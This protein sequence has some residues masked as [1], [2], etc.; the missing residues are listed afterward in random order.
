MIETA[1]LNRIKESIVAE[2][3]RQRGRERGDRVNQGRESIIQQDRRLS[4]RTDLPKDNRSKQ[5]KEKERIHF[6]DDPAFQNAPKARNYDSEFAHLKW[7]NRANRDS[8]N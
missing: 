8:S 5:E 7:K 1:V 3:K 2:G 6:R 4:N